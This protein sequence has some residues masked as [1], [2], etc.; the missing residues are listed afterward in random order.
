MN[1]QDILELANR[2]LLRVQQNDSA[3]KELY[4]G[5]QVGAPFDDGGDTAAYNHDFAAIGTAIGNNTNLER[6]IIDTRVGEDGSGLDFFGDEEEADV[7]F[8]RNN[9][10]ISNLRIVSDN[11]YIHDRDRV[12]HK[13]L[14]AYQDNHTHLINLCIEDINLSN[15]SDLLLETVQCCTNLEGIEIHEINNTF[16]ADYIATIATLRCF[17][18]LKQITHCGRV[19]SPEQLIAIAESLKGHPTLEILRLSVYMENQLN[20]NAKDAFSKLL[21]DKSSI[22][23]IYSSNHTIREIKGVQGIK[24]FSFLLCLNEDTNKSRV[25]KTKI[26]LFTSQIDMSILFEVGAREDGERTIKAL[27]YVVKSFDSALEAIRTNS[28]FSHRNEDIETVDKRKLSAI[29]QFTKAMPT[30]LEGI[31]TLGD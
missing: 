20:Q 12:V 15:I 7:F 6:L 30:L 22:R 23:N 9:S 1:S 29:Y 19:F 24:Q 26:I 10:S 25:A 18:N 17:M 5:D 3:L 13:V 28:K 8:L 4:L 27:P 14:L 11:D 31:K 2:N 21:C 16:P